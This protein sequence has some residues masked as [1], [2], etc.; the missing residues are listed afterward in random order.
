MWFGAAMRVVLVAIVVLALAGCGGSSNAGRPLPPTYPPTAVAT[1]VTGGRLM[2]GDES[3]VAIRTLPASAFDAST[4]VSAGQGTA[5]DGAMVS[6]AHPNGGGVGDWEL[7][8]AA[9]S[10]W[11]VWRPKAVLDAVA[12]APDGAA[13]RAVTR[14]DWPDAC[15]GAGDSDESCAQVITPGYRVILERNGILIEYHTNLVS[16]VRPAP[17]P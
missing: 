5:A 15:L 4:L 2:L 7:V 12:Q 8:S 10:T 9:D 1:P 17:A 14:V 16:T 6:L 11:I 3:F 13:L